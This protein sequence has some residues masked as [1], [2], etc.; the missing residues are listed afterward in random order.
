MCTWQDQLN[1]VAGGDW[2]SAVFA[3]SPNGESASSNAGYMSG[4]PAQMPG[5]HHPVMSSNCAGS[6]A[7]NGAGLPAKGKE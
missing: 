2:P 4:C 5:A 6:H 7:V 3:P 1:S